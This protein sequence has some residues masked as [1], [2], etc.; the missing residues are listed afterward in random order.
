MNLF[1]SVVA[2]M[3]RQRAV[4]ITTEGPEIF[5][6]RKIETC[7]PYGR[8]NRPALHCCSVSWSVD[9]TCGGEIGMSV[10]STIVSSPLIIVEDCC[11]GGFSKKPSLW[12]LRG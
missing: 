11:N 3:C 10:S 6:L 2:Y 12:N 8:H 7:A 1:H 9:A 5:Q 4:A